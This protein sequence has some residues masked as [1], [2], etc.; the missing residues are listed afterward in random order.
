MNVSSY[1][2]TQVIN[3]VS[4]RRVVVWFDGE[5]QFAALARNL[6][7][8]HLVVVSA[9]T[10]RLV[11]RREADTILAKMNAS[12][13]GDERDAALLVYVPWSRGAD[14]GTRLADPFEHLGLIGAAFGD[15]EAEQLPALARRALPQLVG[16]VERLFR[17][18]RPTLA[19]LD[20]L[21]RGRRGP[22][23]PLLKSAL[24]T[25][26]PIEVVAQLLGVGDAAARLDA[27][28]GARNEAER[29][30]A[31]ELD[32]P[33]HAA[34]TLCEKVVV[35]LGRYVLFSE[36]V[37]DLT[38]PVPDPLASVPRAAVAH[39]DLVYAVC[40]RLRGVDELRTAYMERAEHVEREL[41]L[42]ELFTHAA[43]LGSRNTFPF[44]ERLCLARV[45][46]LA[47]HGDLDGAQT[48]AAAPRGSVWRQQGT[49]SVLWKLAARCLALLGVAQEI[50]GS[51]PAPSTSVAEWVRR[52]TSAGGLAELDLHQRRVEQAA[53]EGY[54]SEELEPLVSLCRRR[55]AAITETLQS[56]FQAAL[57]REG[58]PPE[59]VLR[60]TQI[61]D[62]FVAPALEDGRRVAFFLVDGMRFEMGE[63]LAGALEGLGEIQ[64]LPAAAVLPT[65]TSMGMAALLPGADSSMPLIDVNGELVPEVGGEAL[66]NSPA[67][68]ELLKHRFG[69]RF[70]EIT[71]GD[72]FS[73][74]PARLRNRLGAAD[75]LVVRTQDI[76]AFGE[77]G[78]LFTA[79]KYMSHVLQELRDAAERLAGLGF[80]VLVFAA[81]HGHVLLQ[82]IPAG[83]VVAGPPGEWKLAKRRCYLGHSLGRVPGT[84][85]LTA[86]KVGINGPVSELVVPAGLRVFAAG[87]GYFHGG[88]SLQEC[89]VPVVCLTAQHAQRGAASVFSVELKY[90]SDRFTS[91]VIGLKARMSSLIEEQAVMRIEAFA[92]TGKKATVVGEA[93]DCDARDPASK[94][95]TLQK[96]IDTQVP[97][98]VYDDFTAD[99]IEIR[100]SDPA[101]GLI[102]ARLKLKNAVME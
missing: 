21:G 97:V 45:V 77:G 88:V 14:E 24:G 10:S 81:D 36:F 51:M 39:R 70:R 11:A 65:I 43:A 27:T 41:R 64:I 75:L 54:E 60:Q 50:D 55:Y 25:E 73:M 91:R 63:D 31:E 58:W 94:L 69:D 1:V 28:A 49:R 40:D 57:E 18:G 67:R 66:A 48:A 100:A 90:R 83:D 78:S 61:F 52:Y 17:E 76:D 16:E 7:A 3:L 12:E 19:M 74:S 4:E 93:A 86:A 34:G 26:T 71:L 98:R 20:E 79:R 47:C 72:L 68:M 82:E 80:S 32:F 44:E 46:A 9:E 56:T 37:F 42:P 96:D 15:K 89:V 33:G 101:T 8:P 85:V 53:A 87:E 29:L 2:R 30:L 22:R 92:G 99:D 35:D 23:Y 13:Q 5:R 95:I 62:R 6:K 84:V 102:L 38:V 59:G